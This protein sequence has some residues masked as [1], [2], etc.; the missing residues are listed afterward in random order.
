MHK[1]YLDPRIIDAVVSFLKCLFE[2]AMG[3]LYLGNKVLNS[4]DIVFKHNQEKKY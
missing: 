1:L 4:F 3:N 2:H